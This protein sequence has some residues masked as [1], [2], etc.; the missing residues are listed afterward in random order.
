MLWN[1]PAIGIDWQTAE[2]ILSDK[3]Q[4]YLPLARGRARHLPR[5]QNEPLETLLVT[6][7]NGQVGWN[8]QRT[9]APLGEVI[10]LDREQL[11]LADLDASRSTVRD[12]APDI[13]VN[14]AAYTAVDKA[15]SEPDLARTIN[16]TAPARM[17][18]G[19]G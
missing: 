18:A 10:A 11:D 7:A 1:D 16:A 14:A 2:P 5:Y 4:R 12:F 19:A 3:D 13:V 15:E 8:L 9:L 17:A 6:G